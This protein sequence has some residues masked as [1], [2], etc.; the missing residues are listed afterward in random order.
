MTIEERLL[1]L[2]SKISAA[3][4]KKEQ[5]EGKLQTYREDLK[6]KFDCKTVKQAKAKLK[7]MEED[8]DENDRLLD[9][10]VHRLEKQVQEAECEQ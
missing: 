3:N 9:A 6:E 8:I 5:A 10:A 2:K 7:K 4:K 1:K